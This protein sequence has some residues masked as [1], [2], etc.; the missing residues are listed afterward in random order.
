MNERRRKMK[1]VIFWALAIIFF[2][3]LTSLAFSEEEALI[4]EKISGI[5]EGYFSSAKL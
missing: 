2:F 5:W 1:K 4:P 3:T